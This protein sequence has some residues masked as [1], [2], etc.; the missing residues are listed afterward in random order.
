MSR[1]SSTPA[2]LVHPPPAVPDKMP[3]PGAP[4]VS[5]VKLPPSDAELA[6]KRARKAWNDRKKP[7]KPPPSQKIDPHFFEKTRTPS[8][9]QRRDPLGSAVGSAPVDASS[10][11]VTLD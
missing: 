10:S 3:V 7:P 4:R 1:P 2:P 8:T 11:N 5:L 9:V 6:A